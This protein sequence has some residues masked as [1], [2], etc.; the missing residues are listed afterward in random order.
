MMELLH[1]RDPGLPLSV[2]CAAL[3]LPRSTVYRRRRP[4]PARIL[5]PRPSP[6]RRLSELEREAILE[7]L[8]SERFVD[9]PPAEV[10]AT[11]LEEGV[12]LASP[13]TMYRVLAAA[14]ETKE[15]R[16][17][18]APR[19]FATPRLAASAPNQVWTWDISKLPTFTAGVFLNLYVVLDLWSRYVVAWMIAERENS[20][21]AKQ[22]FAE[23]ISRSG[24]E[25]DQLI[26]HMD[27]GAPMTSIGFAELLSVLGV[28]RSHSRPRVSNDN[29]F[30]E[31][32]FKTL[33]YQP[34]YPGAFEGPRDARLWGRDYFDWYNTAHH[35]HGL[36]LYT[37]TT[38]YFGRLEEAIAQRQRVLDAAYAHHPERFIRGRP[39][40]K[41]P[42][43]TVSINPVSP[44]ARSFTATQLLDAEHLLDRMP[45][46][47]L[48]DPPMIFVPSG[49]PAP[50]SGAF[51]P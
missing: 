25:P 15:R 45:A 35:H 51:R 17:Q 33:K 40:A 20:A 41:R 38:L 10:Y 6:A 18:R 7:V 28:E 37:P 8:H 12:F 32:Q 47:R 29:A 3:G 1:Q 48:P 43:H 9:Q 31:S 21:L 44:D 36:A 26:V 50:E 46:D 30:S 39:I 13:R 4:K 23:A 5:R 11:L 24:I 49:A 34:D 2:A 22:L 19:S 42:P 14:K 16:A 27:R